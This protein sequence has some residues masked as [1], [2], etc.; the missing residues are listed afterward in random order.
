MQ[1]ISVSAEGGK[2]RAISAETGARRQGANTKRIAYTLLF[3][4]LAIGGSMLSVCTLGR[5]TYQ[6]KGFEIELRLLPST[7][8]HTRLRLVPLGEVRANTHTLP[9]ALIATLEHVQ[10]EELQQFLRTPVNSDT[11]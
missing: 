1:E 8:G 10:V 5:S 4:V 2:D 9:V 7:T 11:L 6:W 3:F